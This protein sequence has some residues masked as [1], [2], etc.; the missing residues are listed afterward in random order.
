MKTRFTRPFAWAWPRVERGLMIGVKLALW[1]AGFFI[2]VNGI[3]WV[4]ARVAQWTHFDPEDYGYG[5]LGYVVATVALF[6]VVGHLLHPRHVRQSSCL[7]ADP[8]HTR[9]HNDED[10]GAPLVTYLRSTTITT[11]RRA[12]RRYWCEACGRVWVKR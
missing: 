1:F 11:N 9:R 8:H 12:Y 2:G 10:G 5:L 7:H 6:L 3:A 4:L